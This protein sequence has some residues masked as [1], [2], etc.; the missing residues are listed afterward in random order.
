ML[1]QKCIWRKPTMTVTTI[2]QMKCACPSCLCIVNISDAVAKDGK[3]FCSD[4]C[5]TG[6]AEG[7][8]CSHHGCECHA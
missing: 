7:I 4:T 5:A 2:T 6:H 3:Y 1:S 8:G